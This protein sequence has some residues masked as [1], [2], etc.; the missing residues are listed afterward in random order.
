MGDRLLP[1]IYAWRVGLL[2]EQVR[3]IDEAETLEELARATHQ[4]WLQARALEKTMRRQVSSL[5]WR[6]HGRG[7]SKADLVRLLGI[8][9]PTLN[10]RLE[11]GASLA[12]RR[13]SEQGRAAHPE[14]QSPAQREADRVAAPAV[15]GPA[16]TQPQDRAWS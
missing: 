13:R 7:Y 2:R 6:L 8:G 11:R 14:T 15:G 4:A 12:E 3:L 5:A 9:R 1:D 10:H 16:E